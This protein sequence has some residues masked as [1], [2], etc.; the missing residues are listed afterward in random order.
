MPAQLKVT[1]LV[2]GN[3]YNVFFVDSAIKRSMGATPDI[4]QSTGT[5]RKIVDGEAVIEKDDKG[6][7]VIGYF[8]DSYRFE[9]VPSATAEA[10]KE[11]EKE[12]NANRNAARG[13][14]FRAVRSLKRGGRGRPSRV[15]RYHA[16]RQAEAAA[17]AAAA[18]AAAHHQRELNPHAQSYRPS[19]AAAA[20]AAEAAKEKAEEEELLRDATSSHLKGGY[21]RRTRKTKK[22]KRRARKTRRCV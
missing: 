3:R 16:R 17:A 2:V 14:G 13:P 6:R 12:A 8:G 5:F 10:A 11:R 21:R 4:V 15:R 20:A 7:A 18:E 9:E 1:D 19:A 22:S